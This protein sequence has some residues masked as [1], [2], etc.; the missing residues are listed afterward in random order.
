MK[1]NEA[2][3]SFLYSSYIPNPKQ[4]LASLGGG[5]YLGT[6]NY[7]EPDGS[8]MR[9]PVQSF[10][11]KGT[12]FHNRFSFMWEPELVFPIDFR[13]C[14]NWKSVVNLVF[15]SS[16][17]N[18][19][20]W[21]PVWELGQNWVTIREPPNTGFYPLL[22]LKNLGRNRSRCCSLGCEPQ[23]VRHHIHARGFSKGQRGRLLL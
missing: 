19:S 3:A 1:R 6:I 21:E 11:K 2:W 14:E 9:E 15:T 8:S 12:N 23:P 5:N 20:R 13:S 4:C 18:R 16:Y 22:Y 7:W 17:V 10:F